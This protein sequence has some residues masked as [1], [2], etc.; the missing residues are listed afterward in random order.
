MCIFYLYLSNTPTL[1]EPLKDKKPFSVC[2]GKNH[3]LLLLSDGEVY[4]WGLNDE[5]QLGIS[6]KENQ[7]TPIHIENLHNVY[8]IYYK[9]Y[10]IKC[11]YTHSF[12]IVNP[13]KLKRKADETT[14]GPD[15]KKIK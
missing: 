14:D 9:I 4:S 11:G 12:A 3:T 13:S 6:N 5:G 15:V 2:C 1:I 7:N 8:L 10:N